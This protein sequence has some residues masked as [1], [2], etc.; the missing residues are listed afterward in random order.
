LNSPAGPWLGAGRA[1]QCVYFFLSFGGASTGV[2]E[3]DDRRHAPEPGH[4]RDVD[5]VDE[6]PPAAA[7]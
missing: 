3:L 6:L 4:A 7:G 2:D 5:M 1:V